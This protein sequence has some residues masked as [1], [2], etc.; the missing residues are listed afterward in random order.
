MTLIEKIEAIQADNNRVEFTSPRE[1]INHFGYQKRSWGNCQHAVQFLAQHEIELSSDPYKEWIG[2]KI[3]MRHKAIATTKVPEDAVRRIFSMAA[4]NNKPIYVNRDDSLEHAITLMQ[5]YDYSQLPVVSS[6]ERNIV[7]FISW[8]TIGIALRKKDKGN[9]VGD[10]MSAD[11]TIVERNE[12]LLKV[13]QTLSQ[14]EFV[15]VRNEQKEMGGI[16]TTADLASE[17]L[18]ITQ[19]EAFLLL[20]QIELQIRNIIGKGNILVE[21]LRKECNTPDRQIE[22]I[23]DLTFG[24]YIRIIEN[25]KYWKKLCLN[26]ERSEFVKYLNQVREVRNDVMHFEPDGIKDD[27]MQLLRDMARYLSELM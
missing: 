22:S 5:R 20:E 16:V 27:K 8:K 10:Y 14:K 13:I 2:A 23:D 11:V 4:A 24:E 1:L 19:A 6:S 7:G 18:T 21:E 12:P 3:E 15:I 17:F 25:P 9:I 26:T